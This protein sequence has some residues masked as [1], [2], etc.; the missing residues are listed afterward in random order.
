ME[1]TDFAVFIAG[2]AAYGGIM[3]WAL[4]AWRHRAACKARSAKATAARRA[5]ALKRVCNGLQKED[6]Q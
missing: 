4:P 3:G 1:L 6:T 5:N 2:A